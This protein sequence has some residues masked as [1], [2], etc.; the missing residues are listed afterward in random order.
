MVVRGTLERH[1]QSLEAFSRGWG[2]P[3]S[4]A[5]VT[6][7]LN[8]YDSEALIQAIPPIE[9][10]S[11][12]TPEGYKAHFRRLREA[13]HA[14]M[15]A[16]IEPLGMPTFQTFREGVLAVLAQ[17]CADHPRADI[18]VFSSGGPISVALAHLLEAPMSMAVE[19]NLRLRNSSYSE[20]VPSRSRMQV[21]SIN[22]L[23]HLEQEGRWDWITHA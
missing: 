6:P 14:W 18:V 3:L 8:E 22:G 20:L 10:P 11:A 15:A 5:L 9:L 13:L 19:L 7:A 23:A 2:Q 12:H 17:V 1:R 21:V 4:E 16:E